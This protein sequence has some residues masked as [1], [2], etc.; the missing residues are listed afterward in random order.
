MDVLACV[1]FVVIFIPILIFVVIKLHKEDQ[2]AKR[3]TSE[4]LVELGI[5][6]FDVAPYI[7]DFIVA[8]SKQGVENYSVDKYFKEN[9]EK[10]GR[11]EDVLNFKNGIAQKLTSILN[12]DAFAEHRKNKKIMQSLS[13]L[14]SKLQAYIVRIEYLSPAGKSR[15]TKDLP[16]NRYTFNQYKNN[17]QLYMS[18]SEYNRMVR[19]QQLEIERKRAAD[20][21]VERQKRNLALM[22]LEERVLKSIGRSSWPN[23]SSYDTKVIVSSKATFEKYDIISFFKEHRDSVQEIKE[24]IANRRPI[25]IEF[26]NFKKENDFKS[27]SN[28]NHIEAKIKAIINYYNGYHISVQQKT[29]S[30]NIKETKMLTVTTSKLRE[31]EKDPMLLMS[32]TE[33]KNALKEQEKAALEKKQHQY[34]EWINKVIDFANANKEKMII[35]G[36]QAKFDA[37]VERLFDRTVNSIKKIKTV[38]SEEWDV[39]KKFINGILVEMKEII[40]RNNQVITY[41]NSAEFT[42]IKKTCATIMNSQK[43]FNEYIN[44]KANS[45]SKLFGT[46]VV[47]TETVHE[48]E[49]QYIRPYKKTI[50]PF[51][52]EVSAQVFASAENSPIEYIVKNFYPNK[53]A[54]P[55]QI[56]KLHLL[57]EEL[58]TLREAREIIN[59]YKKQYEQYIKDVPAHVMQ[60]DEAGFYSRLGFANIDEEALIIQY[61]FSYTSNGGLAQR[62]FTVPMTEDVI[63]EL[64]N[65]L[66]SKLTYSAFA[67][68]QRAMMTKKLREQIK[69]RDNYTCCLCGNSTHKEPNLLLEIDHVVPVARGGCTEE[70]NLQTLCWKCNRSKG[71]KI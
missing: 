23:I 16:I 20:E 3:L 55:D 59:R 36:D 13:Q 46:R 38:D 54:Y 2:K 39:I 15:V 62:S 5:S 1:F 42:K 34:Y 50:T 44:E 19:E 32:K 10:I 53:A 71:S 58:E 63:I 43:E 41:Y 24:V 30:G 17:P 65:T 66:E 26:N 70:S 57:I 27:D 21:L 31:I 25:A 35:F 33:Q 68:E 47:R 48:D 45:I 64:I 11:I 29:S 40:T 8:K 52:A 67:K 28:Y 9:S 51:T 4:I 60:Y 61:K 37:I 56:L 49:Y 14:E 6:R 18:A 22:E 12:N 7:D 69:Q